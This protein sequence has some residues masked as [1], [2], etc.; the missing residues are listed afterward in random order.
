MRSEQGGEAVTVMCGIPIT[1]NKI[2]SVPI[3]RS[4]IKQ[5]RCILLTIISISFGLA[6][7]HTIYSFAWFACDNSPKQSQQDESLLISLLSLLF[8]GFGLYVTH[9]YCRL[10]LYMFAWSGIA[11]LIGSGVCILHLIV[12]IMTLVPVYHA[13]N[14]KDF[15]INTLMLLLMIAVLHLSAFVV[16]LIVIKLAFKLAKLIDANENLIIDLFKV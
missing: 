5:T 15:V 11:V 2:L 4:E 3:D 13:T 9:N 10:G 16:T 1:D 7:I 8:F 6:I 14:N 12:G